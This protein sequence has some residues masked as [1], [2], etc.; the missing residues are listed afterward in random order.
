VIG[1]GKVV[2]QHH[3]PVLATVRY[4]RVRW[5]QDVNLARARELG[6]AWS[7]PAWYPRLAECTDVDAVLVATPVGVR[8]SILDEVIDRNW[9]ALCEKPF[10]ITR[11]DHEYLLRKA[12]HH[13]VR[14][15]AGYMRRHYWS[16]TKMRE[17]VRSRVLGRV[18]RIVAAEHANLRRTGV[19]ADSYRNNPAASG[20]GVMIETG[21]HLVDQVLFICEAVDAIVEEC[22]QT[23]FGGLD[24]ETVARGRLRL[25]AGEEVPLFLTVSGLRDLWGGITVFCDDGELR[26]RLA[27]SSSVEITRSGKVLFSW[28]GSPQKE[29][30]ASFNAFRLEWLRFLTALRSGESWCSA[31]ETGLLTTSFVA[32]CYELAQSLRAQGASK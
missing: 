13:K 26:V 8:K 6:R 30:Q 2:A 5:L 31:S 20:G 21:S 14:L 7:V 1:A 4:V 15:A 32:S 25:A 10:A 9:H 11:A 3:L 28:V 24:L 22:D 23:C 17:L 19:D 27:P 16:T 29:Q 18:R 12:N